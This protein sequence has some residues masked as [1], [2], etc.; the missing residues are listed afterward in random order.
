MGNQRYCLVISLLQL[1]AQ[2]SSLHCNRALNFNFS[3]LEPQDKN[4]YRMEDMEEEVN[5]SVSGVR[6]PSGTLLSLPVELLVHI[7]AFLSTPRDKAKLRYVSRGLR[8]VIEAPSLWSDFV[9][10]YYDTR[11]E[12]CVDNLFKSCGGYIKRLSFP[13]QVPPAIK[14][15]SMLHNCNNVVELNLPT[16]KLNVE[17][18]KE[19]VKCLEQLH[20]LDIQWNVDLVTLLSVCTT[21]KELTVRLVL[22]NEE[23][24]DLE[25]SINVFIKNWLSNNFNPQNINI[26]FR[27][28]LHRDLL[29][30][31][32]QWNPSAP[33]GGHVGYVRVYDSPK[34][35]L[36]LSHPLPVFQLRF[37]KGATLPMIDASKFGGGGEDLLLLTDCCYGNR[38][39][40]K[41]KEWRRDIN[42]I[43]SDQLNGDIASLTY[44]TECDLYSCQFDSVHLEQ[45]AILCPNLQ[46]LNL[47]EN[48]HCLKSLHGLDAIANSCD[49]LQGL[50]LSGIKVTDVEDH[51]QL[52]EILSHMKLTHLTIS[53]CLLVPL[54]D[55]DTYMQNFIMLYEKFFHLRALVLE[56]PYH[57]I[58][59]PNC[60]DFN[61]KSIVVLS[62]FPLLMYCKVRGS[63]GASIVET[64]LSNCDKLTCFNYYGMYYEAPLSFSAEL[65]FCHLEQLC[66]QSATFIVTDTFMKAI[67][68]H[69][70]LL[71]L[72]LLVST[73]AHEGIISVIASSCK[74]LTLHI[75]TYS[76]VLEDSTIDLNDFETDLRT[77]FANRKLFNSG[78]FRAEENSHGNYDKLLRLN[79]DVTEN[80]WGE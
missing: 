15:V 16:T 19:A 17:Q 77:R 1:L 12:S 63:S 49:S 20:K 36:D 38:V 37:G 35:P 46:R 55:D 53:L 11:E 14:L 71:H 75:I 51:M 21:L 76:S 54:D 52:W 33:A 43:Q 22:K 64:V 3:S 41:P 26:Q 78:S 72:I 48:G 59:C 13:D 4:F 57:P 8:S 67:S 9:W 31:W 27:Y 18:L 61:D 23:F 45:L 34:I 32:S 42:A 44:V 65:R 25:S 62:H 39:T 56:A 79:I 5:V 7:I 50:D 29:K 73:V 2:L 58:H 28:L 74:L 60:K 70:G 6:K 30:A 47:S 66:L 10:P 24:E 69:G 80:L 40:Y 68:A